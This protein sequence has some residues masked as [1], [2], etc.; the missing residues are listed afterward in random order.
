MA[1]YFR[2]AVMLST[3]VGLPAAWIY[4]GPLPAGAQRVVD[5]FLE[6]AREAVSGQRQPPVSSAWDQEK[7]APRFNEAHF[8]ELPR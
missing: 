2:A 8:G 5:R 7:T 6:V 4:Y 3:L 1:V